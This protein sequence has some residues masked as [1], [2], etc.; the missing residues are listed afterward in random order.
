MCFNTVYILC[1]FVKAQALALAQP[2]LIAEMSTDIVTSLV[3]ITEPV[4][5]I[6]A[7]PLDL[8]SVV[9]VLGTVIRYANIE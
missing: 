2:Q 3:T 8:G 4:E 6:S 7:L 1:I 5:N 9:D